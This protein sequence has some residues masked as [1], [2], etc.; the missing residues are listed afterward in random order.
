MLVLVL[1]LLGGGA[2]A[3]IVA[4][5]RARRRYRRAVGQGSVRARVGIALA[6]GL[7]VN[8]TVGDVLRALVPSHADWC[9]LHL[10]DDHR[11]LRVGLAHIDPIMEQRMQETF[12]RSAF[13]AD[14]PHGPARVIRTGEPML[15]RKAGPTLLEGQT[16]ADLFRAAGLGSL[17]IVPLKARHDT[18][19]ALTL[20]RRR[21]RAYDEHD[22]LWAEDLAHR[23]GLAVENRRLYAHARELFE[24]SV[25]ANF[26]STAEGRLVACNR[27][28]ATLLGFTSVHEALTVSA[29]SLYRDPADRATFLAQLRD[30]KRMSDYEITLRHRNGQPV[31]VVATAV[32]TFDDRGELVKITGYLVDRTGQKDLE[33][34]LRQAQRLEAVGQLAGGIAHD[35]NNLL[36]VIIGC[37]DL[38]RATGAFPVVID[39]HDPLDALTKAAGRAASLTQQLLAFS[40]R[41]VLQPRVIDM[42][43]SL[44]NVHPLLRRLTRSNVVLMLDLNPAIDRVQVDPGQLDQVLVNL[45]VNS[46]DAMPQGGII[47]VS[48]GNLELTD[49]DVALYPYVKRGRYVALTVRDTGVGMDEATRARAFE[50]FFTTKPVGK[51]TGLGLST[52][53]GIVKQSGGYVWVTSAIDAGTTVK[54]CLP[55][56]PSSDA[57]G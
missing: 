45:V 22:L 7:G 19:G 42:N 57:P 31:I 4:L 5:E 54:M 25:S 40:R 56:V 55:A 39:G 16:D 11:I 36:T 17:V 43:E 8:D 18:L 30:Q 14:A 28:F 26:V 33:Q 13:V 15:I 6:E 2:A 44:R 48:S 29:P 50:P 46:T 12:A 20:V 21:P 27:T 23:I 51:G 53:Y 10:V 35:F 37:A 49:E 47:T 34:Q 38:M 52:V 24:Q 41:Q 9:M 1:L 3:A 32:G